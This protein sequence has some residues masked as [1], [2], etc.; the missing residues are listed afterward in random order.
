MKIPGKAS[1]ADAYPS[2]KT[3]FTAVLRISEPTVDMY[4]DSLKAEA[5]GNASVQRMKEIMALIC[6]LGIGETGLSSLVEDRVLPLKLANGVRSF[7]AAFSKDES[8]EFVVAE[9]TIHWEAFEDQIALLDFSLEEIRDTRPLLLALG[10][11]NRFSSKLVKEITNVRGGSQ[12]HEMTRNLRTK[13]QAIAR[14]VIHAK[15]SAPE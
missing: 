7:S 3:F 1:I 6:R 11:E 4:V 9:N 5:R 14:Y 8:I 15:V 2:R 13:S 10:L 12:D